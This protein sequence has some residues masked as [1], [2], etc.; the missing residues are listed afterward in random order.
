M[1]EMLRVAPA[2]ESEPPP[3]PRG[4]QADRIF[5]LPASM[6]LVVDLD[7][8]LIAGCL[9]YKSFFSVLSGN[10]LIVFHCA[11]WLLR[12][13]AA[14]KRELAL[15]H[16]INWDR[17]QLHHDVL[18]LAVQEKKAGRPI[19]LATAADTVLA[20]QLASRLSFIDSVLASDG[21]LN[22]KGSAK[23][24]MLRGMFPDGFIYVG[25]SEA[26]LPVWKHANGIV[27]VNARPTVIEAAR[28]L[29][30]PT[31]ELSGRAGSWP[32]RRVVQMQN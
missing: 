9:F 28:A 26:D 8:T 7:G 13:P 14:L 30:L 5:G 23:A 18:A 6:P 11:K 27:L 2:A 32:A 15:R 31:L 20:E 10:P 21:E 25:D 12:G 29:R 4:D 1:I 19:V 22:F 24:D 17:L 16:R 3:E